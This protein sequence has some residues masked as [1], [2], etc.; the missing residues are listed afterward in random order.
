MSTLVLINPIGNTADCWQFLGIDGGHPFEYPGHGRRERQPGWT[1]ATFA[2]QIVAAFDGPIDIV[3]MSMGGTVVAN[4]LTRHPDRVRSAVIA[5]S[6]SL[7]L[8]DLSPQQREARARTLAGRGERGRVGGMA[9]VVEETFSR[10]FTPYGLRNGCPGVTYARETLLGMDPESWNDIWQCQVIS[11]PIPTE[12]I[13]AIR[14]PVSILG[15]M[16]DR[17]AGLRGLAAFHA[18]VANSR[19]EVL[20]GSHMMHLEQPEMMA[21][22]LDRHFAWVESGH[23]VE[24]P[25]GTSVWSLAAAA[26]PARSD[27]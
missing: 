11:A 19:Y 12:Q 25:M 17:S 27:S 4:V 23:R 24:E 7:A 22:A 8:A 9:A 6:G 10:W 13:R 20:P 18:L 14:A 21:A 26:G 5:C 3:G 1:H 2:D 15:G 16:H